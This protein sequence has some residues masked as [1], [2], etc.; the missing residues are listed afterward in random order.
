MTYQK[1]SN[2]RGQ[3]QQ[4]SSG[5]LNKEEKCRCGA[6]GREFSRKPLE[7]LHLLQANRGR[8]PPLHT[9]KPSHSLTTQTCTTGVF[10]F[11]DL[12]LLGNKFIG[13]C[14]LEVPLLQKF[15]QINPYTIYT[16]KIIIYTIKISNKIKLEYQKINNIYSQKI[17]NI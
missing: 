13:E 16:I 6:I 11:Q 3:S 17:D 15:D 4:W 9:S 12:I 2:E 5:S 7:P 14:S 1:K 8:T 10:I